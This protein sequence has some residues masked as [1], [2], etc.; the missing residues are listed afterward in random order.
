M[1]DVLSEDTGGVAASGGD[2][3]NNGAVVITGGARR[4]GRAL[5]LHL[6]RVGY[7]VAITFNNSSDE[8]AQTIHAMQAATS[9]AKAV[10]RA[11][12]LDLRDT[13]Q[14]HALLPDVRRDFPNV[15]ALVNNAAIFERA[16]FVQTNA[17]AWEATFDAHLAVNL[18]AP[19]LLCKAF[20]DHFLKRE[21]G[22]ILNISDIHGMHGQPLKNY[23]AYGASKAGVI[24][25]TE[26]LALALAPH[27]RVNALCPGT[28]LPP[29]ALNDTETA[30]LMQLIP[31]KR[32]GMPHEV[33]QAAEF[34]LFGP[35]FLT[36]VVL[37]LDGG[38][39]LR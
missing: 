24:A 15:V 39:H 38:R 11:Y 9:N 37:P 22:S 16:P 36:G 2:H 34:L 23:A 4:L 6:A 17:N 31:V 5:A 20:G 25:L 8:A 32:L 33:A 21:N 18:K 30:K 19:F 27:V 13:S 26:T 1:S 12:P 29:D 28:I 7:S 10:F 35:K 14:L 3:D